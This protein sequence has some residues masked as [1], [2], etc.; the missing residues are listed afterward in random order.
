ME[1]K[2]L[3]KEEVKGAVKN[4]MDFESDETL[5]QV[6]EGLCEG[7]SVVVDALTYLGAGSYTKR[8]KKDRYRYKVIVPILTEKGNFYSTDLFKDMAN[9]VKAHYGTYFKTQQ[10]VIDFVA[11]IAT[12]YSNERFSFGYKDG[13]YGIYKLVVKK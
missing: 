3:T 10:L 1:T 9:A 13:S 6:V 12:D 8:S 2:I 11:K 7:Y 4:I 5:D